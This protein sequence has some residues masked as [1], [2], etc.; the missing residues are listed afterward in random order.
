MPAT[1]PGPPVETGLDRL[2]REG[3]AAIKGR[4]VG[5]ITNHS[6]VDHR[7][8][9][10]IDLLLAHPDIQLTALFGPEHGVRGSAQAGEIVGSEVDGQTGLPAHS[11]YGDTYRP[12]PDMLRDVECL[13]YDIQNYGVRYETYASTLLH[14]M[15]AAAE[16]GLP[17]VVLDRPNP[18]GGV[19]VQGNMLEPGWESFVGAFR[20]PV[21]HGLSVG[22]HAG[23]LNEEL[24]LSLDLTVIPMR[25]WQRAMWYD[26]TGIPWMPLSPNMPALATLILYPGTCLLE[27]TN[28]SEGRGTTIPFEVVGAPWLRAEALVRRLRAANLPG[29]GFR[30]TPFVPVFSK[31]AGQVCQGVQMHILDR[32]QLDA[33]ALGVHL[34]AALREIHPVEFAWRPPSKESNRA[35]ID[36]LAGGPHLREQLDRDLPAEQI[37]ASW[38]PD[39]QG[40]RTARKAYLL[41]E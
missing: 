23:M 14:C 20:S 5:L 37:V 21:R 1:E 3:C 2:V 33:S 16:A 22:E 10:A 25:G 12:T 27:G 17:F 34:L 39:L 18:L 29:I 41:Y 15:R 26:Q 40:F 11:L 4:R 30:S 24:A 13:V 8:D 36:L 38:K 6:A 32:D 7:L 9:H 28:L 19:V 31:H 35:P